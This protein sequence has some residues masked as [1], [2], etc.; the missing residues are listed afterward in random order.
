M[1]EM[2]GEKITKKLRRQD[3]SVVRVFGKALRFIPKASI[4]DIR[5]TPYEIALQAL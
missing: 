5:T 4:R 1:G 2:C 3:V